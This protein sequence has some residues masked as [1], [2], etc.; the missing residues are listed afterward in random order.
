MEKA[1]MLLAYQVCG[2]HGNGNLKQERPNHAMR[3]STS[4]M[5]YN[6]QRERPFQ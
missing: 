4:A 3:D 6:L 2:Y 1:G 5:R